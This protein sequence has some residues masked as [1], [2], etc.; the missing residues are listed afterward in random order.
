VYGFIPTLAP[1]DYERPDFHVRPS[2]KDQFLSHPAKVPPFE[3][4]AYQQLPLKFLREIHINTTG[5]HGIELM[6][7]LG[8]ESMVHHTD[9][10]DPW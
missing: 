1:N 2:G 9:W 8:V 5:E 3:I 4:K 10:M 7:Q 6:R